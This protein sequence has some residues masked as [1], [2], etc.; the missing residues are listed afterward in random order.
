M[1]EVLNTKSNMTSKYCTI[2]VLLLYS[3]TNEKIVKLTE[4]DWILAASCAS[5]QKFVPLTLVCL[6]YLSL[7]YLAPDHLQT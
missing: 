7:I 4:I 1:V 5:A 3:I 6:P 2:F